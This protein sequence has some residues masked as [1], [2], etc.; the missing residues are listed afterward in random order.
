MHWLELYKGFHPFRGCFRWRLEQCRQGQT[1]HGEGWQLCSMGTVFYGNCVLW[2]LIGRNANIGHINRPGWCNRMRE[3]K[4]Q[5]WGVCARDSL[6]IPQV[7]GLWITWS[8]CPEPTTTEVASHWV[9]AVTP[10]FLHAC[11]SGH[12]TD[13]LCQ[14]IWSWA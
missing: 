10:P 6:Q 14:Y 5:D 1:V 12:L 7:A 8:S 3:E 13:V 11:D 9:P 2:G 4:G